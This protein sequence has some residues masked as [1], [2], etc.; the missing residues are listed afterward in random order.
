MENP[1]PTRPTL[2]PS[3]AAVN[4][5]AVLKAEVDIHVA[6]LRHEREKTDESA[7][8][9]ARIKKHLDSLL[10]RTDA[11]A[12]FA[13]RLRRTEVYNGSL[14]R[15]EAKAKLHE[16]RRAYAAAKAAGTLP[17]ATPPNDIPDVGGFDNF[18]NIL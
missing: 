6:T 8:T 13:E 9:V 10:A 11:D 3:K 7:A 17:P 15:A 16:E 18:G 4:V 1:E 2:F 5:R 12:I 14:H